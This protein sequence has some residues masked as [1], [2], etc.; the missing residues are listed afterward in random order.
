MIALAFPAKV[1]LVFCWFLQCYVALAQNY[2]L[3]SLPPFT[4]GGAAGGGGE[5]SGYFSLSFCNFVAIPLKVP[6]RS[7]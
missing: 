4:G 5:K 1:R 3:S 2:W 6:P 7:L